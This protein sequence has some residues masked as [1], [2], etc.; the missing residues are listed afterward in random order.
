MNLIKLFFLVIF[1]I[2]AFL[3]TGCATSVPVTMSFPQVPEELK[4]ACP[5]LK[6]TDPNTTKLS[7]VISVVVENYGQ[8]QECRIKVD[9]WVQWYNSQKK[10]F[11]T[12]K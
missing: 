9:A 1:I 8:Y 4:V 3:I 7:E 10:I 11:E 5:D 12:V 6:E 2:L